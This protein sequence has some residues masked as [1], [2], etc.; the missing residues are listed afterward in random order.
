M[1]HKNVV[2]VVESLGWRVCSPAGCFQ[3]LELRMV[4]ALGGGL[5]FECVQVWYI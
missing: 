3:S 4:H 5:E 1:A 2:Q